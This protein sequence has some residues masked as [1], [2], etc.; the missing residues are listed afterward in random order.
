[1]GFP[2]IKVMKTNTSNF[3]FYKNIGVDNLSEL[4]HIGGFDSWKDMEIAYPHVKDGSSILEL[5][6]AY[7]RCLDYLLTQN[8]E[9]EI[10][11][12]EQ[13][14]KFIEHLESAYRGK[15]DIIHGDFKSHLFNKRFDAILWM[16]SGILDFSEEEQQLAIEKLNSILNAKGVLIIDTPRIGFQTFAEHDN[17][18][19]LHHESPY[20][21]LQCYIPSLKE[22]DT[23]TKNAG[24]STIEQVDYETATAKQRSLFIVKK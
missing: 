17:S 3:D 5:G 4:A 10:T 8:Y 18:Q 13:S 22:L 23:L 12:I 6:A 7:G 21:N 1:M 20:G 9:G 16:W 11:A 15:V 2:V 24:F 14:P 19:S